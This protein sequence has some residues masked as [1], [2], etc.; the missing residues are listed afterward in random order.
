[1]EI[2]LLQNVDKLGAKDELVDVKPGYGRNYLIPQKKAVLAIGKNR[3]AWA[4]RV[5]IAE[6][7]RQKM[8]ERVDEVVAKL[9]N[10][11]LKIGAKV[12]TSGKI[13][14]S[15]TTIQIADA[16]NKAVDFEVDRKK[17]TL[18]D[19]IKTLGTYTANVE[20]HN[21]VAVDVSFEVV[22]E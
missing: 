10:T 12:G 19:D 14:G 16:V 9:K 22:E 3:E 8:L 6:E 4:E 5:R 17:I 1:M 18:G 21:N 20:L 7:K 2:I 11:V 15:V 13:F